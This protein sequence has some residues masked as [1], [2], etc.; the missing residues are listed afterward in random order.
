MTV[1][2]EV[3]DSIYVPPLVD[4][5][6]LAQFCQAVQSYADSQSLHDGQRESLLN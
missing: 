4:E 5:T 1:M 6:V 2:E 3:A